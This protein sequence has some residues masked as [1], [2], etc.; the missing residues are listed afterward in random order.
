MSVS[1][2]EGVVH[3]DDKDLT[4]LLELG[5]VDIAR[6]VRTGAGRACGWSTFYPCFV[7]SDSRTESCGDTDDYT[8]ALQLIGEVDLVAGGVLDEVQA[9][10]GV[11]LL[12]ESGRGAVKESSL[13]A[14]AGKVGGETTCS[15]HCEVL[16]EIEGDVERRVGGEMWTSCDGARG[17]FVMAP[18]LG[19]GHGRP[20]FTGT[21][22][23]YLVSLFS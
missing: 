22:P 7:C 23:R 6:N 8:L 15:K 12:D 2:H 14:R 16:M 5:V 20:F 18:G 1:L 13:G 17:D 4:G 19:S 9:G 21:M 11:A 3:G 10:N